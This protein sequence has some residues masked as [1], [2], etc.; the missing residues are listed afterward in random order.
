MA[1]RRERG[2]GVLRDWG[3]ECLESSFVLFL[4]LVSYNFLDFLG[5]LVSL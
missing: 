4:V 5:V 2:L 1:E 3:W